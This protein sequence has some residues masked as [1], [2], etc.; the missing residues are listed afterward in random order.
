[1][2]FTKLETALSCWDVVNCSLYRPMHIA[3]SATPFLSTAALSH[4]EPPYT[5]TSGDSRNAR[6]TTRGAVWMR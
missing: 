5:G 2:M 6:G 1:M 4:R 3:C